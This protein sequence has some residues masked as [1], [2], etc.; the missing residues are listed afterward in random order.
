MS[1]PKEKIQ[2]KYAED[3]TFVIVPIPRIGPWGL[4][5]GQ[6]ATG[7]GSKIPTDRM[8]IFNNDPLKRK[9][10]VYAICFSNCASHYVIVKGEK[11]YLRD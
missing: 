11:L 8:L 5:K 2:I 1:E 10:R 3:Y 9:R 7:Y 6:S 4:I